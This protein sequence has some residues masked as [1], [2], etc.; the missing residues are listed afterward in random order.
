MLK[1]SHFLAIALAEEQIKEQEQETTRIREDI[2]FLKNK[3][4]KLKENLIEF[5]PEELIK[6]KDFKD[7]ILD[8]EKDIQ[9]ETNKMMFINIDQ[10]VLKEYEKKQ[11][12]FKDLTDKLNRIDNKE[13]DSNTNI[14]VYKERI[15]SFYMPIVQKINK[16][17]EKLFTK[18]NYEGKI[19]LDSNCKF[20]KWKLNILVKFRS[21]DSFNQL[22]S[23]FQSG[24]ER[25]ISTI[26]FILSLFDTSPVPFRLVDEI[27]QGM[28]NYNERIIHRIIIDLV[29][30]GIDGLEKSETKTEEKDESKQS[31]LKGE[32]ELTKLSGAEKSEGKKEDEDSEEGVFK[33]NKKEKKRED[34][35]ETKIEKKIEESVKTI[36]EQK[37]GGRMG[38]FFIITPKLV[39][40]LYFSENMKIY[41]LYASNCLGPNRKEADQDIV[42]ENEKMNKLSAYLE[43]YKTESMLNR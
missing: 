39:D 29:N 13:S 42:V 27:N 8:L 38:Q 10:N 11:K 32:K 9:V 31:E 20:V 37:S 5:T 7:V 25:S 19:E 14:N 33:R 2:T 24:G 36:C 28:D 16:N 17:F 4:Y 6:I 23:Y 35:I 21:T 1:E 40:D 3:I 12:L 41:V 34:I 26:L 43:R 22:N 18:L 15:L 30:S